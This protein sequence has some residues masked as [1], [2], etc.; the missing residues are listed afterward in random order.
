MTVET[1]AL[2]YYFSEHDLL[3]PLRLTK[4]TEV[5]LMDNQNQKSGQQEQ[6]DKQ[7]QGGQQG[8][9]QKP[10]QGKEQQGPKQNQGGGQGQGGSQGGQKR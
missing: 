3:N 6:G 5:H 10:E 7:N 9:S 8:G 1:L 4:A 2:G